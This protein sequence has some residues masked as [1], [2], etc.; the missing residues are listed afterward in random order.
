MKSEKSHKLFNIAKKYIPG[1]VNSPVR[2]FR[3]VGMDPIFVDADQVQI[4]GVVVGVM[5]KY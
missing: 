1:G 2:A 5:R 4:Q 3:N